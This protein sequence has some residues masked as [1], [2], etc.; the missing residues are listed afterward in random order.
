MGQFGGI[1]ELGFAPVAHPQPQSEP[2]YAVGRKESDGVHPLLIN[3]KATGRLFPL[4]DK[5]GVDAHAKALTWQTTAP[6]AGQVK[7]RHGALPQHDLINGHPIGAVP[8][9]K[10][11]DVNQPQRDQL[12]GVQPPVLVLFILSQTKPLKGEGVFET[13]K[14]VSELVLKRLSAETPQ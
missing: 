9:K 6:A 3:P 7:G 10:G 14:G 11:R 2:I 1:V 12:L 4:G 8:G 5:V 13:L